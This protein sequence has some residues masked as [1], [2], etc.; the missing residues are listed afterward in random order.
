MTKPNDVLLE[1]VRS[2]LAHLPRVEEKRMFGGVTFMVNGKMCISVGKDRIMCRIDPELHERLVDEK[3]VRTVKMKGRSY[4][5]YVHVDEAAIQTQKE[6]D[7]WIVL[8]LEQ[9]AKAQPAAGKRS[10][11]TTARTR[12]R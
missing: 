4:R 11:A 10:G 8:A 6:F 12:R 7:R 5:G 9:N 3:T 2:A 1:R